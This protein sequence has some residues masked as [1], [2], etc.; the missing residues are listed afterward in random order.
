MFR[1]INPHH[2]IV[3]LIL[4]L[5]NKDSNSTYYPPTIVLIM[6]HKVKIWLVS[7]A[8]GS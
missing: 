6:I 2:R 1:F 8:S 3:E 5:K 7:N 4:K